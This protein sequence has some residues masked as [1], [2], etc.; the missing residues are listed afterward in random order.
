M[1]RCSEQLGT[2][3]HSMPF[4]QKK[5]YYASNSQCCHGQHWALVLTSATTTN[6]Q[7]TRGGFELASQLVT[8]GHTL[9]CFPLLLAPGIVTEALP[10][11][12]E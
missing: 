3:T 9:G 4:M 2:V 5:T 7:L 8:R 11:T 6:L 10:S 1:A 12:L